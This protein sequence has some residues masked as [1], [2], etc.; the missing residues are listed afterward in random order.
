MRTQAGLLPVLLDA[1]EAAGLD[2]SVVGDHGIRNSETMLLIVSQ[3]STTKPGRVRCLSRFQTPRGT[4]EPE[5]PASVMRVASQ[6]S[7]WLQLDT[8]LRHVE[9][10]SSN[11]CLAKLT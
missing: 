11:L 10:A 4:Q 2:C 8:A 7:S 9:H 1:I 3:L 5:R 6:A